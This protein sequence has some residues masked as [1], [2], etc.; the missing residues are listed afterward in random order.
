[1]NMLADVMDPLNEPRL[2][3]S[4]IGAGDESVEVSERGSE[5]SMGLNGWNPNL[6]LKGLWLVKL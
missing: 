3:I 5:T 6:T 4:F 2:F 1:M